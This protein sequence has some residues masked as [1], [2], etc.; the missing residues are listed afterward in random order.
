MHLVESARHVGRRLAGRPVLVSRGARFGAAAGC[1]GLAVAIHALVLPG[2]AAIPFPPL[3]V[4]VGL[5]AWLGGRWPGL[6]AT[7]LAVVTGFLQL[8]AAAAAAAAPGP[9]T[10]TVLFAVLAVPTALVLGALRRAVADGKQAEDALRQLADAMPQLVWMARPD[11]YHDYFNGHWYEYTGLGAGESLGDGWASA[12]HPD[13]LVRTAEQWRRS[14]RTGESY[15]VEHRF[16]RSD[17]SYRWFLGRALPVRNGAGEILRWIG[18]STDIHDRKLAE[19]ALRESEDKLRETDRRRGDFLSVLSHELRNPLAPIRN[20][21][22][23]LGRARPDSEQ[24]RRALG[25]IDR[26]V[27]QLTR[28]VDDLLDATRIT[29]GKVQIHRERLELAELVVH[30][31]DDHRGLFARNGV[32]LAV[33]IAAS[34]IQIEGDATRLTQV[35]GNLL[36]NAAKFTPSGGRVRL[37]VGAEG[38]QAVV[39]VEDTGV[40]IE[41]DLIERL[42]EPFVQGDQTLDRSQGGL[43]LGLA[44][45]KALVELQGGAVEARSEG[46]GKGASFTVRLPLDRRARPRLEV[47]RDESSPRPGGRRVMVVEDN[48]DAAESLKAVLEVCGHLVETAATGPEALRKAR[49]VKPDLVLCDIGLPGM[50]GFA[51]ARAFRTDPALSDVR[52]VALSGYAAAEDVERA[53]GAGFDQHIAKP[54]DLGTLERVLSAGTRREAS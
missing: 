20:S 49:V 41:P 50:D 15:E 43:G 13:D 10:R 14:L 6:L 38:G 34:P 25:V 39:R 17:G 47:V 45:V 18:T 52:L 54:V 8:H 31:G 24:A 16:R 40:G 27:L 44:L 5:A 36:Q 3:L 4:A 9:V 30:A 2:R 51:V 7:A 29:R 26:Q 42:F 33:T 22:Y 11:G 23:L 53:H 35:V 19:A 46:L 32:E 37:W 28:L 48:P 1:V 12:L 21:L